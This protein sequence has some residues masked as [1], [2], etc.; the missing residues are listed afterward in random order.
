MAGVFLIPDGVPEGIHDIQV[1]GTFPVSWSSCDADNRTTEPE[2]DDRMGECP[3]AVQADNS[4]FLVTVHDP[5]CS[6]EGDR[7]YTSKLI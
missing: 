6:D 4:T 5:V 3:S 7:M 1:E 2:A